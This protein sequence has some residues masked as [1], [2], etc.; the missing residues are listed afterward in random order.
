MSQA[1]TV[2]NPIDYFLNVVKIHYSQWGALTGEGINDVGDL[3]EFDDN[4]IDNVVTNL[5]HP[6]DIFILKFLLSQV[7]QK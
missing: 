7:E 5:R 2:S 3:V 1:S 6:Q 4:D